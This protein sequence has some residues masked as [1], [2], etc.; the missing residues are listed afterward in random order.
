ME[1]PDPKFQF[2]QTITATAERYNN[3]CPHETQEGSIVS[4]NFIVYDGGELANQWEYEIKFKADWVYYDEPDIERGIKYA[5]KCE[6]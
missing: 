3:N 4:M 1:I 2:G 5:H 6:H